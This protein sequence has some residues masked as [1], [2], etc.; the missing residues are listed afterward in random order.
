MVQYLPDP[1]FYSYPLFLFFPLWLFFFSLFCPLTFPLPSFFFLSPILFP[2]HS[3]FLFPFFFPFLLLFFLSFLPFPF[4]HF[5]HRLA[6]MPA[7][8]PHY[9]FK[10]SWGEHWI[11]WHYIIS[12]HMVISVCLQQNSLSQTGFDTGFFA[13]GNHIF[14]EISDSRTD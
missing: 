13:R 7:P 12:K 11:M 5:S 9:S 6:L 10:K 2:F 14:E 8:P 4:L 1:Q 3:F